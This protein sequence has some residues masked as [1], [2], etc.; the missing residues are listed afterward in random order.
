MW[1]T[2]HVYYYTSCTTVFWCHVTC[3]WDNFQGRVLFLQD[4]FYGDVALFFR[5]KKVFNEKHV[6]H[7]IYQWFW[8]TFGFY[9]WQVN[10]LIGLWK[11][12]NLYMMTKLNLPD[13]GLSQTVIQN[14]CSILWG[15][16]TRIPW[17]LY[18]LYCL[19]SMQD[20]LVLI[21]TGNM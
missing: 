7:F 11:I 5:T 14:H 15:K 13:V 2:P 4:S 21:H 16:V 10:M 1:V 3:L 6:K 18:F 12:P 8:R 19:L 20:I 9:I 17:I